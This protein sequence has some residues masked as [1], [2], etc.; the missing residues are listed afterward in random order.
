ML[1]KTPFHDYFT[2]LIFTF[3]LAKKKKSGTSC[4]HVLWWRIIQLWKE[5]ALLM[6]RLC[7]E[8][9]GAIVFVRF[10]G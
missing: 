2:F 6:L 5:I 3:S 8:K 1:M 9:E 7:V 10:H 4:H